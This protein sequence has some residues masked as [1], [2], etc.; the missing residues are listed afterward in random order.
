MRPDSWSWAH[1]HRGHGLNV[2][3]PVGLGHFGDSGGW[4]ALIDDAWAVSEQMLATFRGLPLVLFA[5]SMGSFVAQCLMAER[6]TAYRAVVLSGTNGRP[7]RRR[8]MARALAH[9][10]H[11]R[12][13]GVSPAPGW[14]AS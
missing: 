8:R 14:R 13:A 1:D 12:W 6:G 4:R 3:A 7:A 2:T 10:Q 9:A 11:W 5:H